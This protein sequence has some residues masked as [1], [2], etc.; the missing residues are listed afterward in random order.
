MQVIGTVAA[1]LPTIVGAFIVFVWYFYK[2]TR[3][4][5]NL[6]GIAKKMNPD[7]KEIHGS[8]GAMNIQTTVNLHIYNVSE[9]AIKAYLCHT[10]SSLTF[11]THSLS[12]TFVYGSMY[13]L[14]FNC[15]ELTYRCCTSSVTK[16]CNLW[17]P[18]G[19][20]AS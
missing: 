13:K 18:I 2:V 5:L 17:S 16:C 12:C 20:I 7:K 15:D 1:N 11:H 3:G 4:C 19:T 14:D 10:P 9:E 8:A 6:C